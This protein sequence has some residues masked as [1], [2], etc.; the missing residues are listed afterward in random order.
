M[1][2]VNGREEDGDLCIDIIDNG[3]GMSPSKIVSVLRGDAIKIMKKA[4]L[5]L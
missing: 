5:A 2:E 1:I 3:D 4:L